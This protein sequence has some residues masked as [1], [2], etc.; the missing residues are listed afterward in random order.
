MQLHGPAFEAEL[1]YRRE[2]AALAYGAPTL[3][4]RWRAR[5]AAR[6]TQRSQALAARARDSAER[7]DTVGGR[8]DATTWEA[9]MLRRAAEIEAGIAAL[10]PQ[11]HARRAA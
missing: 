2:R 3:W 4:T 8:T 1:A 10:R 5:R 9:R 11:D 6:R 7:L